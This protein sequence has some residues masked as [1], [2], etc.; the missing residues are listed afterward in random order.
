MIQPTQNAKQSRP[1]MGRNPGVHCLERSPAGFTL[2]EILVTLG[3]IALLLGIGAVGLNK[4]QQAARASQTRAMLQGLKGALT[5]YQTQVQY[6][7]NHGDSGYIDWTSVPGGGSMISSE[8]LVYACRQVPKANE[9]LKAAVLS[10]SVEANKRIFDDKLPGTPNGVEEIYDPWGTP[11]VYRS[12]N[13][14]G[15]G[16]PDGTAT[17]LPLDTPRYSSKHAFFVSAGPDKTFNT[18]DDISTLELE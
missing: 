5:E 3:I 4:V 11:I 15:E 7:P 18:D 14:G 8:R 2:I 17:G 12:S 9:Q 1:N 10:G 16:N 6:S 13:L